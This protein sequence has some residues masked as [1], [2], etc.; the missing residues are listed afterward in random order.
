MLIKLL[1]L[2]IDGVLTDGT[3]LL[4]ES[5]DEVRSVHFHDL[6]AIGRARAHG[7][8]IATI[9]G[10]DTAA[11]H[12]VAERF[13]IEDGTWGAKDKLSA[14]KNVTSRL[15]LGLE[16]TCYVGDADRDVPA[17]TAAAI[18]IAPANATPAARAAADHVLEACGGRGAVAEALQLL[19][20]VCQ[21]PDERNSR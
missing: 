7:L 10:E 5:G 3:I 21:L 12:R 16:D 15:Q 9:S 2:D 1:A 17:L 20:R 6:D 14:L 4:L 11:G 8:M 13:A 18:G 19:E